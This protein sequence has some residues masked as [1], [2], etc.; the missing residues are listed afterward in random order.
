MD[1]KFNSVSDLL[2]DMGFDENIRNDIN[3]KIADHSLA[4]GLTI[5]RTKADLSQAEM[6][7][8]WAYRNLVF[9]D[10]NTQK[11]IKSNLVI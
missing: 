9:P 4:K 10:L 8:K 11:M 1:K 2:K 3:K 6:A 5:L 7:K